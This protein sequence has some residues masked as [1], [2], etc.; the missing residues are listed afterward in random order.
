[1]FYPDFLEPT[2][3]FIWLLLYFLGLCSFS[4]SSPDR[5][6][7]VCLTRGGGAYREHISLTLAANALDLRDLSKSESMCYILELVH[8][9][10][11]ACNKRHKRCLG[12]QA[13]KERMFQKGNTE[14]GKGPIYRW[15][16]I[17]VWQLVI[18]HWAFK[19]LVY[20]R[21]SSSKYGVCD[22]LT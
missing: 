17:D 3:I 14:K 10:L 22:L 19:G 13:W 11:K 20:C 6:S 1:M 18:E 5:Y 8:H 16:L 4:V 7:A 9:S 21:S 2:V 12:A 15:T